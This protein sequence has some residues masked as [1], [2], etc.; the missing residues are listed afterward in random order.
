MN[1]LVRNI[2]VFE[3]FCILDT[4]FDVPILYYA[5]GCNHLKNITP[6]CGYR[7]LQEILRKDDVYVFRM[8][9]DLGEKVYYAQI[10]AHST[11]YLVEI[12]TK[13]N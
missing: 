4:V 2:Y 12:Q 8:D 9:T 5:N 10:E 7:T 6:L 13:T 3:W 11:P 1:I